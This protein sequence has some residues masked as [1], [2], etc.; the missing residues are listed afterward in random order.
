MTAGARQHSHAQ[1]LEGA[2]PFLTAAQVAAAGQPVV[3]KLGLVD[4]FH[5]IGDRSGIHCGFGCARSRGLASRCRAR[6]HEHQPL[7]IR[8]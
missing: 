4:G 1:G 8:N 7:P 3:M 6:R 2:T 5:K